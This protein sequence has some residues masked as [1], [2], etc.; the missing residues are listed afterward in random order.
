MVAR[1]GT[2]LD[3]PVILILIFTLI[4][5][6]LMATVILDEVI[7]ATDNTQIDQDVLNS[8]KDAL[9]IYDKGII[10]LFVGF[11]LFTLVTSLRIP[12]NP[13]FFVPAFIF[14]SLSIWL[15]ATFSNVLW[16]F[17]NVQP[18]LDTVNAN[19]PTLVVFVE[20]WP[21]VTAVMG[22]SVLVAL[23]MKAQRTPEAS[24]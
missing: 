16:Q 23:Y 22:L 18:I 6:V 14:L 13:V 2:L 3:I 17:M 21:T 4:V 24:I 19:Y 15:A 10:V 20:N 5:G 7:S 9:T 8:A 1:R 12:S 11:F